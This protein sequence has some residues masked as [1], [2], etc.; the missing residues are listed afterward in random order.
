MSSRLYSPPAYTS[1][2]QS[3]DVCRLP[4]P[5]PSAL[6]LFIS[7][8]THCFLHSVYLYHNR[9]VHPLD[10]ISPLVSHIGSIYPDLLISSSIYRSSIHLCPHLNSVAC[11]FSVHARMSVVYIHPLTTAKPRHTEAWLLR[12]TESYVAWP[13]SVHVR[14]SVC[15]ACGCTWVAYC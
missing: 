12:C 13:M 7:A 2:S 10:P 6:D 15:I 5:C 14:S 3:T 1:T 8:S 4:C 9:P 11:S